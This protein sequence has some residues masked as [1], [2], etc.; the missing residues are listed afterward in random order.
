M[1][2]NFNSI[3]RNDYFYLIYLLS[4]IFFIWPIS[5][6]LIYFQLF[7]P[8]LTLE[9]MDRISCNWIKTPK[10]KI[11]IFTTNL[12][13]PIVLKY[14]SWTQ[15]DVSIELMS[16]LS[17]YYSLQGRVEFSFQSLDN[18]VKNAKAMFYL[19]IF[20]TLEESY[21]IAA[22]QELKRHVKDRRIFAAVNVENMQKGLFLN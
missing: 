4:C 8:F 15:F 2:L 10:L 20:E 22:I 5:F 14:S 21:M 18:F 16:S 19:L 3:M 9:E 12:Q 6:P 1:P 17:S 7:F 11:V 13:H